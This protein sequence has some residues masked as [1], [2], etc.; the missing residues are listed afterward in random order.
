MKDVNWLTV[1][2]PIVTLIL[3]AVGSFAAES[4]RHRKARREALADSLRT[5]RSERYIAF[6][7][8]AH[9]A[10]HTLGRMADGCPDPLAADSDRY[11]LVDSD[12]AQKFRTLQL[13]GGDA[14][15]AHAAEVRS[16]LESFR[17][18]V[19]AGVVYWSDDYRAAYR[20]VVDARNA[21]IAAA[22]EEISALV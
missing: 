4:I 13:V 14:V 9:S 6:I 5:T 8:A 7:D 18:A 1:A 22:R 16:A 20:P 10:A 2:L 12:V 19:K 17:D 21:L 3:G 15:V 11:W